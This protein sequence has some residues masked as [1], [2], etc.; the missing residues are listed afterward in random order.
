M[1]SRGATPAG[2]KRR[3]GPGRRR[4]VL[5]ATLVALA[6]ATVTALVSWGAPGSRDRDGTGPASPGTGNDSDPGGS[7]P[8]SAPEGPDLPA[9]AD[10]WSTPIGPDPALD[11]DSGV[12]SAYLGSGP[13]SA[14]VVQ[15]GI[16]VY[17]ADADTPRYDVDCR[18]DWGDCPLERSPVPIPDGAR[19]S[20]GTD[21]AMAIVDAEAGISYEFWQVERDDGSWVASWGDVADLDPASPSLSEAT[22]AGL[23]LVD[24]LVTP[25]EV[26]AGEIPHALTFST[27]NACEVRFRPPASK[28]DGESDREDCIEQGARIQLDP[29]L[30]LDRLELTPVE[31]AVAS[32]LQ[33]YGAYAR[34][35]GGTPI[36]FI[37]ETPGAE[38][39]PYTAEGLRADYDRLEGIPWDRLRVLERWDGS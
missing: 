12:I 20:E 37:F 25:E 4:Q 18:R 9:R 33:R 35:N 16:P 23:S 17:E 29:D 34:D 38:D 36:A 21:A 1:F 5:L 11:S 2:S 6:V 19:P 32:A 39:P 26:A 24:G 30:D 14:N 15:Y 10:A 3:S 22:G 28:T 13:V 27:N 31:R 7:A 8:L